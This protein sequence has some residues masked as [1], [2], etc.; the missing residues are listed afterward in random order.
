MNKTMKSNKFIFTLFIVLA[1]I[2]GL[3]IWVTHEMNFS[4]NISKIGIC[5]TVNYIIAIA[6]FKLFTVFIDKKSELLGFIFLFGSL[7]KFVIYF[8]VLRPIISETESISKVEF[9]FFFI[10][11]AICLVIE[12][13]FLVKTLHSQ[14][15]LLVKFNFYKQ[16]FKIYY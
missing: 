1:I 15:N 11:Y 4:L 2:F 13:Y 16:L 10:P 14:Q 6:I 3:H 12:I 9:S 8:L 7:F 5:Y